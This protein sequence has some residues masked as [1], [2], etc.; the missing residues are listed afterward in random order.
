MKTLYTHCPLCD[1][2]S[3]K[4]RKI[5]GCTH[6]ALYKPELPTE[7]KWMECEHCKHV[8]TDSYWNDEAVGLIFSSAHANQLPGHDA[9]HHRSIASRMVEK[10]LNGKLASGTWLDIGFGNGALLGCAEEYGFHVVGLDLRKQAVDLMREDGIEAHCMLFEDYKPA[11]PLAVISMADV[12]EHMPYPKPALRHAHQLLEDDGMLFVSMPN[13]DCYAW[14]MLDRKNANPYWGE[15][16]HYHNFGRNRL[17]QLLREH[18]FEPVN[19]G[20]SQRYYLCMEVIARKIP[21]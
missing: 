15:L 7:L 5:A 13:L 11:K 18:G 16:E 8:F 20:V 21:A 3:I 1:N 4:F 14:R 17:F 19:Y 9:H 2:E 12:L 10:V 6:H